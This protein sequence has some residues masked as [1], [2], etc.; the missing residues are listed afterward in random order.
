MFSEVTVTF[1]RV[2]GHT[3]FNN[4]SSPN[5]AQFRYKTT[6]KMFKVP[7]IF[8]GFHVH[9]SLSIE[10]CSDNKN[11]TFLTHRT[12]VAFSFKPTP[13]YRKLFLHTLG[14]SR[15]PTL[16]FISPRLPL[17]PLPTR[18]LL[19]IHPASPPHSRPKG[20]ASG[21]TARSLTPSAPKPK[22]E[23]GGPP[24]AA[25]L[26]RGEERKRESR[27]HPPP[28]PHPLPAPLPRHCASGPKAA[29]VP[30]SPEAPSTLPPASGPRQGRHTKPGEPTPRRQ[31]T[32]RGCKR[33]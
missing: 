3:T 14:P 29:A 33:D 19:G 26:R 25:R 11:T 20:W 18:T 8:F 4:L 10:V 16:V 9:I 32:G 17:R 1:T 24:S 23:P 22:E 27:E 7:N 6:A 15:I 2:F 30:G 28:G 12:Q 5:L 21:R 13:V 31:S